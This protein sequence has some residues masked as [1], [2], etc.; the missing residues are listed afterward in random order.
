MKQFLI[1]AA[2]FFLLT[3]CEETQSKEVR[4]KAPKAPEST[5]ALTELTSLKNKLVRYTKSETVMSG[6]V[7]S[8]DFSIES[9]FSSNTKTYKYI[10]KIRDTGPIKNQGKDGPY[11]FKL[12]RITAGVENRKSGKYFISASSPPYRNIE[13]VHLT[14]THLLFSSRQKFSDEQFF[15]EAIM[16]NDEPIGE[17]KKG[18]KIYRG[19][20]GRDETILYE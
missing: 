18:S 15:V 13:D 14:G 11:K 12:I 17:S 6:N 8:V 2:A 10:I 3:G 4:N 5:V 7:N 19:I 1:L 9:L 20:F 16:V